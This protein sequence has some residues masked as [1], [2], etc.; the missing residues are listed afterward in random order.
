MSMSG[1]FCR[2]EQY[3]GRRRR[4]KR[5]KKGKRKRGGDG[6]SAAGVVV[7][8]RGWGSGR[9]SGTSS[10]ELN[11]ATKSPETPLICLFKIS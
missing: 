11:T 6:V 3:R 8:G 7:Q 4:R 9:E 1:T 10:D 5:E 2:G